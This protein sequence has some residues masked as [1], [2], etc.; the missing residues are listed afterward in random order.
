MKLRTLI[1]LTGCLSVLPSAP[2]SA[3]QMLEQCN[4]NRATS[5]EYLRCLDKKISTLDSDLILWRNNKVLQLEKAAE[6]TGR[7]DTIR[8]FKK[9]QKSFET[10]RE[11]N[12]K[13]QY[14]TLMPDTTAGA[15]IYKECMVA[16]T[17]ERVNQLKN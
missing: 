7:T 1:Y 4:D 16:M 8:I 15:I 17:E 5:V 14:L 13:W 12:C 2:S 10:Y 6:N 9:T 3:S 11:N